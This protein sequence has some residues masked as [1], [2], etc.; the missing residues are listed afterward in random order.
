VAFKPLNN[1]VREFGFLSQKRDIIFKLK[2]K[3]PFSI[4]AKILFNKFKC[5]FL[6]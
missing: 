1:F 5:L 6:L 4:A 3:H 2:Y